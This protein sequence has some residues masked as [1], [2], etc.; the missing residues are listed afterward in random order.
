MKASEL[1]AELQQAIADYGDLEVGSYRCD[2]SGAF[3]KMTGV[4]GKRQAEIDPRSECLSDDGSLGAE[5][6]AVD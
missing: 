2:G 5:F 3:G 4:I 1:V 6:I